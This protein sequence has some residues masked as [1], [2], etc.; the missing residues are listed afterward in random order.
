MGCLSYTPDHTLALAFEFMRIFQSRA[1]QAAPSMPMYCAVGIALGPVEAY[2]PESGAQVYDLFGR[3]IILAT[4]YEGLRDLIFPYLNT[5]DSIIIVQKSVFE[6]LSPFWQEKFKR[7]ELD[8]K[9]LYVRDDE[10]ADQVYYSLGAVT[11]SS[12]LTSSSERTKQE[13]E[14][15]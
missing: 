4:R 12:S 6:Q 11:V 10:G 9:Q 1:S 15:A 14:S 7:L 8:G 3:G 2:Y 5:K 13:A